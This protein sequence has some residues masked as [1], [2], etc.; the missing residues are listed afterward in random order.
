MKYA[1]IA[2]SLLS[3]TAF[4]SI[5]NCKE[6]VGSLD[7]KEQLE[8]TTDVPNFLKGATIMII[9]ADGRQSSVPAEKFKVV[10]RKQ[11]FVTTRTE[12]SKVVSCS[13]NEPNKNRV[14][15]L[16]GYG[17]KEGVSASSNGSTVSVE[18]K[19]GVVGGAQYQRMLDDTWSLGVQGQTNKT[20]SI[21]LGIDF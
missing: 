13:T 21:L 5:P 6:E 4:A 18:S 12:R 17:T 1:I 14:A 16:G 20:G 9:T 15:V 3:T 10:P 2:L 11:Q 19:T 8:I 7:I